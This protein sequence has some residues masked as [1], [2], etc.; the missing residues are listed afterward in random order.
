M[1]FHRQRVTILSD[2]EGF[3]LFNWKSHLGGGWAA[4]GPVLYYP[5][6]LQFFTI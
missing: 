1:V 4:E 5:S 2:V 3:V 6:A